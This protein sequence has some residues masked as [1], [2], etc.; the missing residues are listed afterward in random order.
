MLESQYLTIL[1]VDR[2]QQDREERLLEGQRRGSREESPQCVAS[3]LTVAVFYVLDLIRNI[4]S[5]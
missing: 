2:V 3:V 4:F 5:K 1:L